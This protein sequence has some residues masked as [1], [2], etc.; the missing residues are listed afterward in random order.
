MR[1]RLLQLQCLDWIIIWSSRQRLHI[2]CSHSWIRIWFYRIILILR[3][4]R[5]SCWIHLILIRVWWYSSRRIRKR[6]RQRNS[7]SNNNSNN[8]KRT[9]RLGIPIYSRS[10]QFHQLRISWFRLD[11]QR[12]NSQV[13]R[14]YLRTQRRSIMRRRKRKRRRKHFLN[15][16]C[17]NHLIRKAA[18]ISI[19]LKSKMMM[20]NRISLTWSPKISECVPAWPR[21]SCSGINAIYSWEKP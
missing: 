16:N 14:I 13:F 17:R 20:I 6:L 12:I 5:N 1:R 21:G 9:I 4:R 7:S 3:L 8:N 15:H 2:T 18:I 19:W 10:R 11:R